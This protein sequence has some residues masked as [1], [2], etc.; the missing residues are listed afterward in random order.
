MY[1]SGCSNTIGEPNGFSF[2]EDLFA[3]QAFVGYL[4]AEHEHA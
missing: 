1:I 2:C 4:P 3:L